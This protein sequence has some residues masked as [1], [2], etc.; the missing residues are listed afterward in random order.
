MYLI[1]VGG[2]NVGLHL[3]KKLMAHDHEVLVLEKMPKQ[4]Q[5]LSSALGD[6]LVFLGDGCEVSVQ[7]QAGFGRADV[8]VAVTGED[9]DNMVVCQMAKAFW[10][11]KR[12]VARVNDPSHTK[13]FEQIGIDDVVSATSII[14]NLVEQQ[15][16]ADELIPLGALNKGNIEI[17]E[18]HLSHRSPAIG[19]RVRELGLPN[20]TNVVYLLRAD[21]GVLVSGETQL[22]EDDTVVAL[23]PVEGADQLR[24]L[25]VPAKY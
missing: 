3:A 14:F 23:V 25:L 13:F 18:A 10:N 16:T 12:V 8:V 9:E 7:K 11:V 22:Q 19:K 24:N 5:R 1:I 6:E 15:I 21:Q 4:A 2:G 17:I 20:G